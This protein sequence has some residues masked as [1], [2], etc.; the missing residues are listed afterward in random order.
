MFHAPYLYEL[1]PLYLAQVALTVWMLIDANRRGV[2]SY[3][4]WIILIF[5][6]VGAWAYFFVY[7]V[8]DFSRGGGWLAGLFSR[9]PSLE[10]LRYR[11]A[12]APTVVG[13]LEL[14]ERLIEAGEHQEAQPHLEAVLAREPDH[15]TALFALAEC[16][17]QAD[18]PAQAVPLLLKLIAVRPNWRDNLA[19]HTLIETHQDAGE[20]QEAAAQARKLAQLAPSLEH[21]CLLARC[22]AEGGDP[23]EARRVIEEALEEHRFSQNPSRDDRRWAGRAKQLLAELEKPGGQG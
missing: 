4:L 23:A 16:H 22:L 14:A 19:W 10:E 9:R 20:H 3:W 7:K 11:A 17:R 2:D 15:G 13:R 5:Q 12:Q 1:S 18:R 6:P 8:K 21:K